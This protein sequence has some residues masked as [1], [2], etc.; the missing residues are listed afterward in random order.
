[1]LPC[2]SLNAF[3]TENECLSGA[4][5]MPHFHWKQ[6]EKEI[7]ESKLFAGECELMVK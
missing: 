1:L 4:V 2:A 5:L 3:N 6:E 7:A